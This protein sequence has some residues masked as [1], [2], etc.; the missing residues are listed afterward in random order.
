[1][2]STLA[3]F[4]SFAL[5]SAPCVAEFTLK[6]PNPP[7]NNNS[8][9]YAWLGVSPDQNN[10]LFYGS[11]AEAAVYP[12]VLSASRVAAHYG[13]WPRNLLMPSPCFPIRSV[14][15]VEC[16]CGGGEGG[17][18]AFL[19]QISNQSCK[20]LPALPP[21]LPCS[22]GVHAIAAAAASLHAVVQLRA[23]LLGGHP[24]GPALVRADRGRG[25]RR[26]FVHLPTSSSP[27]SSF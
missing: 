26:D 3:S 14:L 27:P 9:P 17:C 5:T 19:G 20:I 8:R 23:A 4:L 10:G 21:A 11:L 1:M 15:C 18:G 2:G 22:C 13:A 24:H 16:V 7:R 25:D 6:N 12:T